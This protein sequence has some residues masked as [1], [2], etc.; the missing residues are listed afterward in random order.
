MHQASRLFVLTAIAAA[1]TLTAASVSLAQTFDHL[2]CF[3]AKDAAKF[4]ATVN[5]DVL[6][7]QFEPPGECKVAG[8]AK[9][10]CAPTQKEVT[11]FVV[12]KQP[13]TPL[14]IAATGEAIDRVCY[15]V[16]CPKQDI[17][18]EL[19]S[20]QFGSRDLSK[21]KAQLLCTPAIKGAPQAPDGKIVFVTEGQWTGDLGGVAG[22]DA[23][24]NAAAQSANPPLP[25]TYVAWLSTSTIDAKDRLTPAVGPYRLPN[26]VVVGVDT[27]DLI[28]GVLSNA[29]DVNEFGI[30]L[31]GEGVFGVSRSVWTGTVFDGT[32]TGF[33]C[34]DWTD[35]TT[36][37]SA[38]RGTILARD[39]GWTDPS[40]G[41]TTNQCTGGVTGHHLYCFQE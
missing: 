4:A 35:A 15:K 16:K 10:F 24:C 22:A 8:K 18:S 31:P 19:V 20:D 9:L 29:I 17:A 25:G 33:H 12:D 2:T 13:S 6:Q 26:G 27:D 7:D 30:R 11:S 34:D 1:T 32:G 37:D 41:T 14:T 39:F 36:F 3:K 23:K 5:L 40:L 28:D 21:F 38:S